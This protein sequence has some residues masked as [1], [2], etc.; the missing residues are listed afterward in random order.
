ML[1]GGGGGTAG[2][3]GGAPGGRGSGLGPLCVGDWRLL[4]DEGRGDDGSVD[5]GE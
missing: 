2:A 3:M 4:E 1:A 5:P